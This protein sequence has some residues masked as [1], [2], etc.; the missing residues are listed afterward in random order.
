MAFRC[1]LILLLLSGCVKAVP[2]VRNSKPFE[3]H[4]EGEVQLEEYVEPFQIDLAPD[5]PIL[6][7][8][9]TFR[10]WNS[11]GTVPVQVSRDGRKLQIDLSTKSLQRYR[12]V[13][14]LSGEKV[15]GHCI[16]KNGES[17]PF[18]MSK[19]RFDEAHGRLHP[20][21]PSAPYP[22]ETQEV[23]FSVG[24]VNR[25]GTLTL[26][27]APGRYPAVLLIPGGGGS[28]QNGLLLQGAVRVQE[29]GDQPASDLVVADR[30][31][32][33]GVVVLRVD[34]RGFGGSGGSDKATTL[35][36]HAEDVAAAIRLLQGCIKVDSRHI[37]VFAFSR[38]GAIA[39]TAA[40]QQPQISFVILASAPARPLLDAMLDIQLKIWEAK[41][42]S[43]DATHTFKR[44]R[45]AVRR[46]LFLQA[47][48]P[49]HAQPSQDEVRKI[50]NEEFSDDATKIDFLMPAV[51]NFLTTYDS[52]V[53]RSFCRCDPALLIPKTAARIYGLY[54]DKDNIL[55]SKREA[56]TLLR[57]LSA[58][59]NPT[60][61]VI[62]M[63]NVNHALLTVKDRNTGKYPP[64]GESISEQ[65]LH[66]LTAWMV[67]QKY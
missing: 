1:I 53:E 67:E 7:G 63:R 18:W 20:Q 34:S 52:E 48:L 9:I 60:E 2:T 58:S 35:Q 64:F 37:G 51:Q 27:H 17:V 43:D 28:D 56:D 40:S 26:P 11:S 12:F 54:G 13:A 42:P 3:G 25:T 31:T 55:D 62:M 24:G 57:L 4:W 8:N 59:K 32:R 61:R 50:L 14:E 46:A 47:N 65:V 33:A 44:L 45:N 6:R 10:S 22:Y 23:S 66:Q 39:L 29:D 41:V 5:G 30:L 19:L 36:G 15:Q 49:D 38:G 21:I 16:L